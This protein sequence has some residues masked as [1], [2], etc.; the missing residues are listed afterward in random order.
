MAAERWKPSA[1]ELVGIAGMYRKEEIGSTFA[2]AAAGDRLT[3][4]SRVGVVD[5]LPATYH[6]AFRNGDETV[7]FVR[8]RQ[9]R[10]TAMHF[11]SGRAWD[12]VSPRV[13]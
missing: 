11:G 5:T 8:D 6:D 2:V 9:G 7:C 3:V 1:S 10:V 13:K 12:F 4:S